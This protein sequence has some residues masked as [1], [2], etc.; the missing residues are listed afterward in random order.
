MKSQSIPLPQPESII[1]RSLFATLRARRSVR[2]FSRRP[3]E[4]KEIS[5]LL[6]A[7]Q[8]TTDAA[9]QLRIAPSAGA[10]YPLELDAII[11]SGVFRYNPADHTVLQRNHQDVRSRLSSAAL[12]QACLENSSCIFA[13]SAVPSRTLM[14]YGERGT[15]YIHIEVGH[16]V[17]NMLLTACALGLAGVPMGAFDDEAVSSVLELRP[18]EIPLYLVPIGWPRTRDESADSHHTKSRASQSD[19]GR[20]Q[21][22]SECQPT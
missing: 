4:W 14:K 18:N 22:E 17:Q 19:S 15:R 13:V 12:S 11:S 16:A 1:E 10:L 6:W 3:L 7:G 8:G 9:L 5:A 20:K 21:T 2:E